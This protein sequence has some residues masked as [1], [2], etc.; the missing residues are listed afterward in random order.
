MWGQNFE[1]FFPHAPFQNF[2]IW[3]VGIVAFCVLCMFF[4]FFGD[5]QKKEMMIYF[6]CN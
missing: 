6:I 1:K 3:F 2:F 4:C 5:N